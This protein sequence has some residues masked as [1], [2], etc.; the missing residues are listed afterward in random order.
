MKILLKKYVLTVKENVTNGIVVTYYDNLTQ[1]R[2][3]DYI[4][5]EAP[6]G[7]K[8]PLERTAKQQRSIMGFTQIY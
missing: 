1:A 8:K 7:Y 5:K 4:Q 6:E 2:C 3:V